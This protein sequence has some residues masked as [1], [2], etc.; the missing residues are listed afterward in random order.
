M[1]RALWSF[2]RGVPVLAYAFIGCVALGA[3]AVVWH[4][5]AVTRADAA[6]YARA[7]NNARFDSAMIAVVDSNRAHATAKTDTV[8]RTFTA[9]VAKVDTQA[10]ETA[11]L[12]RQLPPDVAALPEVRA[13]TASVFRLTASLADLAKDTTRLANTLA[14]ERA[15]HK[16]SLD[17]RDGQVR[18]ARLENARQ[19]AM[20][21]ALE[22]RP[23]RKEEALVA[24]GSAAAGAACGR[25]C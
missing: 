6:G 7:V 1:M 14:A 19:A 2:F 12:A 24:F 3:S 23:T 9:K 22:K 18:N 16:V 25:W 4:N 11:A 5:T 15:A 20:I 17:V 21:L 8:W 10:I 13:L